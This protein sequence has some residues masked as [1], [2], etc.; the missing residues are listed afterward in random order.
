MAKG[1]NFWLSITLTLSLSQWAREP[2]TLIPGCT[3]PPGMYAGV[4]RADEG[5]LDFAPHLIREKLVPLAKDGGGPMGE[6]MD[7]SCW[8]IRSGSW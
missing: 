7:A 1:A 2:D 8:R 4:R 6:A 5:N 3:Q